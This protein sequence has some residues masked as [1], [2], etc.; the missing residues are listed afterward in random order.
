MKIA[1]K[2]SFAFLI[3]I[4]ILATT[5]STV[6]YIIFKNNLEKEIK[7][8]LAVTTISR[9]NN[10]KTYLYMLK[11]SVGQLSQSIVLQDFLIIPKESS[12]KIEAFNQAMEELV[13]AKESNLYI[14]EFL[15]LDINGKI[16]ASTDKNSIGLDKSSDAYFVGAQKQTYL[17]DAYYDEFLKK[18]LIG[19]SSPVINSQTGEFIGV[20]MARVELDELN[21]I[22]TERTGLGEKGEIYIVNKY[23]YM[24]TP[25][26]FLQDTFLK[27][28][29]DVVKG[30]EKA[31]TY[32]NYRGD[33]VLGFHEYIPEMQWFI[34]AE[35]NAQ[36]VFSPLEKIYRLFLLVFGYITKPIHNLHLGTE[37]IGSGD[38][39]YKVGTAAQDEIGQ[40]SRSFDKMTENLKN[41]TT[42]IE[43]LHQEIAERKKLGE[44][45]RDSV[46]RYRA[47]YDS[48]KDAIMILDPDQGFIAGNPATIAMFGCRDEAEFIN[49]TL[50]SM[51]PECQPDGSLSLV[52]SRQMMATAMEKGVNFFEWTHKRMDGGEFF[53]TVLFTK[54]KLKES[55][56]L[57]ATVRDIT[58]AKVNQ[59]R[60]R[61]AAEEWQMTFDSI[62]ELVFIEDTD[63]TIVKVNKAF[64]NAIKLEPEEIIGKKCYEVL[65]RSDKPW[66]GCPF[67][68]SLDDKTSHS[69][70][71]YDPRIGIPLLVSISPLLDH[72][73]KMLGAVHIAKDIS[74]I[75]Q[76][77]EQLEQYSRDLEKA[78][79]IR[80]EFTSTVS[81][82]LRTPLGPIKEGVSIILD[83][84]VGE[85]N[86][87]QR[88]M[89]T[90]V[91]R[92]A[93]RLNRLINN[94][95]ELQKLES[96]KMPFDAKDNDINEVVSEVHQ[97]M[98]LMTNRKGLG[99][100]LQ[101]QQGLPLIRFDRD[102]ITQVVTNLVNNAIKFTE[103][104]EITIM[105][106][107]EE[108]AVHVMVKDTGPG[109][110][111]EDL[112]R[113]FQSFQRLDTA[114]GKKVEGTGLGLAISKEIIRMH[115][116]KIWVESKFGKGSIFHFSL[117]VI[118]RRA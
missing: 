3:V 27:Q 51:S 40:L 88:D 49:Q 52:K 67:G 38:L 54:M 31:N 63:Y 16:I 7:T 117:P 79:N 95:L 17:K 78:L 8:R 28:K 96:G 84:L 90:T 115:H 10:I 104:G 37:Y 29:V 5:A 80:S 73:G 45:L 60:I 32:L 41:S 113:L 83:G 24:I 71:V 75:K 25:S 53:A 62:S 102:K 93:E 14:Y 85:I 116:G 89:L 98:V 107:K 30:Q 18:S 20:L 56:L 74:E 33:K 114:K 1:T 42:S 22:I 112:L 70:E 101:L 69:Q 105:T 11:I 72:K 92:N 26:Y 111:E 34:L 57:Q 76:H 9:V 82:E 110:K 99:F 2:I 65:H 103:K 47:L 118:E 87:E 64:C 68:K 44:E 6:F 61:K 55:E 66:P 39:D 86:E 91:K 81:H 97:A 15:L 46:I 58:E 109:I 100:S 23:G 43:T 21:A 19:A 77:R 50:A 59:D 48:S 13:R 35:L 12:Q 94:V 108:N 36:E 106:L 4:V